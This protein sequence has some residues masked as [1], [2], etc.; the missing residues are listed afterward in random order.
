M[1]AAWSRKAEAEAL[2]QREAAI[3]VAR[4]RALHAAEMIASRAAVVAV[5]LR[6]AP[7]GNHADL[8][9]AAGRVEQGTDALRVLLREFFAAVGEARSMNEAGAPEGARIQ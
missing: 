4:G 7:G 1:S 5:E 6:A 8:I 2:A 3:Q 9:H